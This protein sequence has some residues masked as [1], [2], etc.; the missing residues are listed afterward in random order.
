MT[1]SG[2]G[3]AVDLYRLEKVAKDYLPTVSGVYDKA[4]G[5]CEDAQR[6]VNGLAGV[7]EQFH[8]PGGSMAQAYGQLHGAITGVLKST[9]TSL[10]ETADALHETVRMYAEAD[11]GVSDKLD[12]LMQQQGTPKPEGNS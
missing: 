6:T 11:Q 4:L 5:H 8:G 2:S 12:R 3:F 9:R 7:P 10:D 1:D